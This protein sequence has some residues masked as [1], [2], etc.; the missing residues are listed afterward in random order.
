MAGY[1]D[2]KI[3]TALF[4]PPA[5]FCLS[6][7]VRFVLYLCRLFFPHKWE[8]KTSADVNLQMVTLLLEGKRDAIF[9]L[10]QPAKMSVIVQSLRFTLRANELAC[11]NSMDA[12]RRL[13]T[14]RLK[15]NISHGTAGNVSFVFTPVPPWSPRVMRLMWRGC[16]HSVCVTPKHL[17]SSE[18][19][20]L[21]EGLLVNLPKFHPA[22]R[23]YLFYSSQEQTCPLT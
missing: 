1:R 14:A 20:H 19:L 7:Q 4:F 6:L 2:W 8:N 22:G 23:R 9:H 21:I 11:H 12:G 15:T 13:S 3:V 10:L 5:A 18:I 17:W 16:T